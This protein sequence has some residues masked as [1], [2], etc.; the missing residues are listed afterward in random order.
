MELFH[1]DG[2]RQLQESQAKQ[3]YSIGYGMNKRKDIYADERLK[4]CEAKHRNLHLESL[5]FNYQYFGVKDFTEEQN[6]EFINSLHEIIDQQKKMYCQYN[7]KSKR[8][9][10]RFCCR[11]WIEEIFQQK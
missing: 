3:L 10:L 9:H 11:E 8:T 1:I 2:F 5:F 4:T 7:K 6:T